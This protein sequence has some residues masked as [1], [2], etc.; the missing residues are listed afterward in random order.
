MSSASALVTFARSLIGKPYGSGSA[1]LQRGPDS[2]DCIGFYRWCVT[3]E[4]PE[5]WPTSWGGPDSWTVPNYVDAWR[6][7]HGKIGVPS[8]TIMPGDGLVFGANAHIGIADGA[9]N[10]ISALNPASG[11]CSVPI[12]EVSLPLT[13][14]I[15]TGLER[16]MA[17]PGTP[18]GIARTAGDPA[19]RGIRPDGTLVPLA[20][21]VDLPV[22][23]TETID[24]YSTDGSP[25]SAAYVIADP[26]TGDPI[27]LL[28]RN[29]TAYVPI[30]PASATDPTV[31]A[32]EAK[33]AAAV[34]A[35]S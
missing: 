27:A 34:A 30:N 17:A 32:L 7:H 33:I 26:G 18:I 5:L 4:A 15:Q 6:A 12:R 24:G 35:L 19:I 13:L 25:T 31:A 8:V 3:H 21:G 16:V 14:V 29:T 11:V 2:F 9:G 22:Y 28:E 20:L 1:A 10:C 23:G